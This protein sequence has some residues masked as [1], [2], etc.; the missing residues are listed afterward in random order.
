MKTKLK[1]ET[2]RNRLMNYYADLNTAVCDVK[3]F[4]DAI[5]KLLELE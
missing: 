1:K 2:I 4:A 5:I 3:R